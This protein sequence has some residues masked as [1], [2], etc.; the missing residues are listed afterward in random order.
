MKLPRLK[1]DEKIN[2]IWLDTFD[3][4]LTTW[5]DD[6]EINQSIQ[7][8]IKEAISA[9]FFHSEDK[10]HVYIYGDKFDKQHSRLIGI[11]KGCIIKIER[12]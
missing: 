3:L 12:G 6:E 8:Q 4:C 1:K 5:A 7:K 9:G 11:P 10:T 2:V